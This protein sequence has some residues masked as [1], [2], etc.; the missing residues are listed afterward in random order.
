MNSATHKDAYPLPRVDDTVTAQ[1]LS[2][3]Q[4]GKASIGADVRNS[5][6]FE[7][8]SSPW[9]VHVKFRDF[10]VAWCRGLAMVAKMSVIVCQP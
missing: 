9:H 2:L 6:S 4:S 8:A 7:N 3:D 5:F 10:S 1:R